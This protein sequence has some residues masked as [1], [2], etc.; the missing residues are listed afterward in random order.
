MGGELAEGFYV[1]KN[2]RRNSASYFCYVTRRDGKLVALFPGSGPSEEGSCLA[3][4]EGAGMDRG[5]GLD[6]TLL[7]P[8]D[9]FEYLRGQT[10]RLTRFIAGRITASQLEVAAKRI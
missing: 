4:V 9:P 7:Q 8:I 1:E 2:F 3:I 6:P 10:E 5:V